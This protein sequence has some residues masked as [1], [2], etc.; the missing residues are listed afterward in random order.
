MDEYDKFLTD[1][2]NWKKE[3][4]SN[5]PVPAHQSY[6]DLYFFVHETP[7]RGRR[8]TYNQEAIDAYKQSRTGFLVL[9]SNEIKDPIRALQ[10]YRD[11][12]EVEKA[13]DNLKNVIDSKRLRVHLDES[14]KG[15]LFI[16]FISLIFTSYI[17]KVAREKDIFKLFGSAANILDEL[18][19]RNEVEVC[20]AKTAGL[21]KR[22]YTESTKS[23][24][25]I[26][27]AFGLASWWACEEHMYNFSAN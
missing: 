9:L 17:L 16:Q 24:R 3:L 2:H 23:Q 1:L 20:G 21:N 6:Y 13:F 19:L 15:R 26:L 4:E 14:M 22:F 5:T 8:I 10:A 27:E 25:L 18:K 11:K 12:D 7:K